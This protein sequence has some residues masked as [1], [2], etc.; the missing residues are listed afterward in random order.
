MC[1]PLLKSEQSITVPKLLNCWEHTRDCFGKC[2][3][4]RSF[5]LTPKLALTVHK[6][7]KTRKVRT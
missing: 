1:E 4:A 5:L 2:T 7:F 3:L 6:A